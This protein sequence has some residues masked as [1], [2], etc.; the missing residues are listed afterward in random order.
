LITP[1]RPLAPD[2]VADHYQELDRY[3]RELWG[4]HV[5]HGLW[6]SGRETPTEAVEALTAFV[7]REAGVRPGDRVCDIGSGYGAGARLVAKHFNAAVTALTIVPAQ[8]EFAVAAG[9]PGN[10]RYFLRDWLDNGLPDRSFDAAYAIESTEHMADKKHAFAEA[11]R[12]LRP[13][14][15]LAVCAWIAGEK[16]RAWERRHLLEPICREGRLPGMGTE[17]DYRELLAAAGFEV[18]AATDI[19][20]E[21]RGT[22]GVCLRRTARRFFTDPAG[23]AFLLSAASRNRVFLVTMARIWLAYRTGAMHYLVFRARRPG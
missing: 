20:R 12:V 5:H 16:A 18:E 19:T 11:L 10:P 3:Y 17:S 8:Y 14:G 23:R 1:R 13:G 9:P 21:V 6:R 2:S 22:W 4:E 7:A 15:R